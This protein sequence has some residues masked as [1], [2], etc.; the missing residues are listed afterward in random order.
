[1][2]NSH[3]FKKEH[4]K[5][6]LCFYRHK[7]LSLGKAA[8]ILDFDAAKARN[9]LNYLVSK[10][11]FSKKGTEYTMNCIFESL[12]NLIKEHYFEES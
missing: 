4:E 9:T 5:A 7:Q 1:M 10:K 2:N 12:N 6:L 8:L 11:A 3:E